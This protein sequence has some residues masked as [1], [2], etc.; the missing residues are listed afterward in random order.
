MLIYQE[1]IL[2]LTYL[3]LPL[4]IISLL[5]NVLNTI[6]CDLNV[7]IIFHLM[8]IKCLIHIAR[9]TL[10]CSWI[11]YMAK[12]SVLVYPTMQD[13]VFLYTPQCNTY[14]SCLLPQQTHD[15]GSTLDIG[16]DVEFRR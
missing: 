10:L 6:M 13:S 1:H 5:C 2:E 4:C 8:K 3:V 16:R 14:C 9:L 11:L 7:V 15:V 12:L